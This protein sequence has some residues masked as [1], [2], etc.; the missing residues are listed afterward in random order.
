[1]KAYIAIWLLLFVVLTGCAVKI[2]E[3]QLEQREYEFQ[4]Y[5]VQYRLYEAECNRLGGSVL[6]HRSSVTRVKYFRA[7]V[8]GPF[9][10]YECVR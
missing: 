6:I 10:R 2:T 9:E 7:G 3:E 8:P 1:M 5:V 4:E